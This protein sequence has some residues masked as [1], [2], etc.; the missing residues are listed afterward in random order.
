MREG[1]SNKFIPAGSAHPATVW[2][3]TSVPGGYVPKIALANSF[4]PPT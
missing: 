1:K 2:I 4:Q 3:M